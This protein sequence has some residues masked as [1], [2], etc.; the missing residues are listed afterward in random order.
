MANAYRVSA[1]VTD[2]E[3]AR[4][5]GGLVDFERT[6]RG[7]VL[8]WRW[9]SSFAI[10]WLLGMTLFAGLI[11][12]EWSTK[13][14]VRENLSVAVCLLAACAL[15]FAYVGLAYLANR[16]RVVVESDRLV[17]S[18]GPIPWPGS[19]TIE[20]A[21]IAQIFVKREIYGSSRKRTV[22]FRVYART[23]SGRDVLLVNGP[24]LPDRARAIEATLEAYLQIVDEPVKGEYR[25]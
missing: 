13:F 24:M 7:L 1:K 20:L 18:H 6:P 12:K 22:E 4:A 19:H 11:W 5:A 23:V 8:Q 21:R 9:R 15:Y 25:S 10:R 2:A 14:S 3:L 17:V 16:T